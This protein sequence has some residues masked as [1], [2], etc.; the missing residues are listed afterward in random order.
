MYGCPNWAKLDQLGQV[1]RH[2]AA[3]VAYLSALGKWGRTQMGSD[4]FNQ[5]L[6]GF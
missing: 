5:I 3:V 6:T 2:F 4:G 1:G